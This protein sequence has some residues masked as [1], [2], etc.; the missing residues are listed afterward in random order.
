MVRVTL[1]LALMLFGLWGKR[2]WCFAAEMY[3]T[4]ALGEITRGGFG[5]ARPLINQEISRTRM[6]AVSVNL[7]SIQLSQNEG[8]VC[9]CELAHAIRAGVA[10]LVRS[11][12]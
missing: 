9:V 8:P 4:W 7:Y 11:A 10:V 2:G 12:H 1:K 3:A 6:S 5:P